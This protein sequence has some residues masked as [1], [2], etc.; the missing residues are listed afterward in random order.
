M[1]NKL[2]MD[3]EV[4]VM[5]KKLQERTARMRGLQVTVY[6][7]KQQHRDH[8]AKI[9]ELEIDLEG[10]NKEIKRLQDIVYSVA[11]LDLKP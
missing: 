8:L 5:K 6:E 7:L 3:K 9:K 4:Y 1:E 10:K 11:T 2:K